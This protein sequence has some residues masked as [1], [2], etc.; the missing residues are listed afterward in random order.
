VAQGEVLR[1]L[2]A[3]CFCILCGLFSWQ[4]QAQALKCFPFEESIKHLEQNTAERMAGGA[5]DSQGNLVLLYTAPSGS[6]TFIVRLVRDG[7]VFA[8][9]LS[10]GQGW[11][12]VKRKGTES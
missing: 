3:L 8:C 10:A 6:W 11:Q 1:V 5:A 7:K 12:A 4:A 9:P 2:T